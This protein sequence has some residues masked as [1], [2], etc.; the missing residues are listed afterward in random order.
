M[1]DWTANPTIPAPTEVDAI[2]SMAPHGDF[3]ESESP[4]NGNA[5]AGELQNG[6]KAVYLVGTITYATAFDG[7]RRET[8]FRY[9]VGG[10]MP[11]QGGE[12]YADE[13]GNDAT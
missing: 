13:D 5:T 4:I 8:H 3:V 1:V 6:T 2:G 9:Y 12:M 7:P 10:N 11:Y